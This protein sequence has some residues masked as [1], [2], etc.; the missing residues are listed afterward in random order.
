MSHEKELLKKRFS[1]DPERYYRVA[2]FDDMGYF[3][4]QCPKCKGF[5]WTMDDKRVTCPEQPCQEYEFLGSPATAKKFDYVSAW[6]KIAEFFKRNGHEE[7]RRYPVVCK[8]R[9]DLYF[10]IASIVDFQRVESGRVVFELPYNPLIVPQMCLR[11][12][13]IANVG[14][15]GRH[16]TSFCMIGQHALANDKG[17][18]KDKC[19]QLDFKLLN[20]EF[21]F[22]KNE[23]VFKED[24]WLGPGAFGNSLEY[25]VK[26]LELG[27][28]VFTA[29]EG[30]PDNYK[31][32]EDR[33]ID[34]GAG[35]ERFVW[36]S[37]GTYNSYDAV[38]ERVLS[39]LQRQTSMELKLDN[40]LKGYYKLAGSLDVDQ[41][42]G[43]VNDYT[44][45]ARKLR[46]EETE[47]RKK[48][49]PI[50]A[51]YSVID[52]ARTLLFAITD[53]MLPSNV[54]GG[55][56]MRVILRRAL[57]FLD[58]FGINTTLT[59][60]AGW[61]AES[62]KEM[63][64]EL[65]ENLS[66]VETILEFE[67]GKYN[68]TKIRASKV[69]ES[70]SRR[71]SS[72]GSE[73][74][75]RLYD[76]DGITPDLLKKAGLDISV[77]NDFYERIT[78]RH[79]VQR[80][81]RKEE[82]FEIYSIPSTKLIYYEDSSQFEF[83][84]HVLKILP[85]NYV[86]LSSTAFYPRGGG[87]E[88]DRGTINGLNVDNVM[89]V[90]NVVLHHVVGLADLRD[91]DHVKGKVDAERRSAI[92]KHHTA[93]HIVNGA[94]RSVLGPWVWQHSAF[95]DIDMGRLDIT[96]FAHLTREN[97]LEIER[98]ANDIVRRNLQVEISWVPRLEAEQ[99]YGFRLYQGGVAP[100]S[101]L[102]VVNIEGFDVEACGGTHVK[103]T[104]EIGLIKIT[105]TERVQDGVER[106]EFVAGEVG[107]EYT[108][109]QESL[110][111]ESAAKLETP[112][113]KLPATVSHMKSAVESTRKTMR[114]LEKRLA[115]L[116][117]NEA[118]KS[119][120]PLDN[121]LRM[122]SSIFEE[123]LDSEFHLVFGDELCKNNPDLIYIALFEENHRTRLIIFSGEIAQASG[124]D[125]GLLVR[126]IARVLGGSGGGTAR[127]AQGGVDK[128]A[129]IVP[130]MS[131]LINSILRS[132]T[133]I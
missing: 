118:P 111:I 87:Q 94:C 25:Y 11:F 60:I 105:K 56:N 4:R 6:S 38:F 88:P 108:Q 53:G 59:T 57:D 64:P 66:D 35:L 1:A 30:T 3:R 17:Y 127:F 128:R 83:D 116:M 67:T 99:K 31:E 70:L 100:V 16:Y 119:T 80:E 71:K 95:K 98:L 97:V 48:I 121:G 34:M 52:H 24:V 41:F 12:S 114:Q 81:E 123:G 68:S 45:I 96:H 28:A 91:G 75:L 78:S 49:E 21:G 50:Q 8:W 120:L 109:A 129:E 32:Y 7:V 132:R 93:T 133:S 106:L 65:S 122:Y 82:T 110:L 85:G 125:A 23:I 107:I 84:A 20:E 77:P 40:S 92:T 69:I 72:I 102:R 117:M 19:I 115:D 18:W 126:E 5:F 51:V 62:L 37:R 61:H 36:A 104:G 43:V 58:H 54:G 103:T 79:M 101:D 27:N 33:I 14:V 26:G 13:D 73:E 89:K 131:S 22:D 63:Y 42:K 46:I 44:T 55:Y 10:T 39:K 130:E 113:E 124:G 74:L 29:Y 9:P 90:D 76:S 15:T 2:L 112:P 47:L 86:V